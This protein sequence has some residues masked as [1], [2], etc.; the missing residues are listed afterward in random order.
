LIMM[1]VTNSTAL[2]AAS[3][4]I[5]AAC[6]A[7][8]QA[9]VVPL[10]SRVDLRM[11][12]LYSMAV[13]ACLLLLMS[14]LY[15]ENPGPW[16]PTV[17]LILFCT[18]SLIRGGIDSLRNVLPM[19][20]LG[21]NTKLL[22][23]FNA[24]FQ[25][26]FQLAIVIGPVFVG[27]T[28]QLHPTYATYMV[29]VVYFLAL[30]AF[31][32][33]PPIS[34]AGSNVDAALSKKKKKK[35]GGMGALMSEL[36]TLKNPLVLVPFIALLTIQGQ[37]LKGVV[38]T[39]FA[40]TLLREQSG[41]SAGYIMAGQGA[42]GVVS[43]IV[44]T[45]MQNACH[46]RY[47]FLFGTIGMFCRTWGWTVSMLILNPDASNPDIAV[48]PYIFANFLYGYSSNSAAIAMTSLLQARAQSVGIMGG[49]RFLVRV[50]GVITKIWVTAIVA[51]YEYDDKSQSSYEMAFTTISLCLTGIFLLPQAMCFL[52]LHFISGV[53]SQAEK[54]FL[55]LDTKEEES[56]KVAT[57][58]VEDPS[59]APSS[60]PKKMRK[61][62]S[63]E[64]DEM[65]DSA[66]ES[67]SELGDITDG[68]RA[69]RSDSYGSLASV[70]GSSV[71]Q[72]TVDK[73]S[74]PKF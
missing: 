32:M 47:W 9:L 52:H 6:A 28:T 55:G 26:A 27:L 29:T 13:K 56:G 11:L 24:Q 74:S 2:G 61:S 44:A 20:Y 21:N 1:L 41:H 31:M 8:G 48:L 22:N 59:S 67:G 4:T 65:S 51:A 38:S 10:L 15:A 14:Y 70:D 46:P 69:Y 58:D 68:A 50:S 49:Q 39:V 25:V 16:V 60:K 62:I 35:K 30:L 66:S 5:S 7:S 72:I 18:D 3:V 73:P 33:M 57:F 17:M 19:L 45:K 54:E 12:L 53:G 42:G 71:M 64:D 43:A 63:L 34:Y 37:R 23:S 36:N 40:K